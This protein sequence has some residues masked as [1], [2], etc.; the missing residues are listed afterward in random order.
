MSL[1][2]Q[3]Y[4][5]IF[6]WQL[7]DLKFD[8]K[9]V[10]AMPVSEH[11]PWATD[12]VKRQSQRISAQVT[13]KG[14]KHFLICSVTSVTGFQC[15]RKQ[16]RYLSRIKENSVGFSNRVKRV[17]LCLLNKNPCFKEREWSLRHNYLLYNYWKGEYQ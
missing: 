5:N 17:R 7:V 2:K 16:Y 11:M 14:W 9:S 1:K 6:L 3:Y 12:E 15:E 8:R 4:I 10:E 13:G